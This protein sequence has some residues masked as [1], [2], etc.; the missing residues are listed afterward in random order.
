MV[1]NYF[2]KDTFVS[3]VVFLRTYVFFGIQTVFNL[4]TGFL[5][6]FERFLARLT[7]TGIYLGYDVI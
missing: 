1:I 3:I 6:K 5:Q 2:L 4:N 7:V